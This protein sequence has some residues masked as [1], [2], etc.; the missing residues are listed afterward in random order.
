V[1]GPSMRVREA[2]SDDLS[3]ARE[4]DVLEEAMMTNNMENVLPDPER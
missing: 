2:L 4:C 1:G 3:L